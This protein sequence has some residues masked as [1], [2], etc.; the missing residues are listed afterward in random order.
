MSNSFPALIARSPNRPIYAAC[1]R[2]LPGTM[3]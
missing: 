3:F 2:R 1:V